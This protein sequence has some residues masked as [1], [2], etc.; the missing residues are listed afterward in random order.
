V[1][2]LAFDVTHHAAVAAVLWR[3]VAAAINLYLLPT[4]PTAANPPQRYAAV[5]RWDRQTDG[6]TD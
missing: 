4:R 5:D 2:L 3:P 6:Q 1:T